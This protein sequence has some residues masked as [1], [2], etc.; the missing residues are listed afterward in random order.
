MKLCLTGAF[1]LDLNLLED[2]LLVVVRRAVVV[3][4]LVLDR[5]VE[6]S[7]CLLSARG[8]DNLSVLVEVY[9]DSDDVEEALDEERL[10]LV[11]LRGFHLE[12]R[13]RVDF[14]DLRPP[15]RVEDDVGPIVA[16]E[17]ARE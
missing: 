7:L 9:G 8:D 15:A 1:H 3:A 11:V 6:D 10:D 12:A 5:E 16:E 13:G 2:A 4:R 14:E 17:A